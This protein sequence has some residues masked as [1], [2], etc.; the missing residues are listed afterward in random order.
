MTRNEFVTSWVINYTTS[1]K[2]AR[3]AAEKEMGNDMNDLV[4]HAVLMANLAY[5]ELQK[6]VIPQ[7]C[8]TR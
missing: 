8:L 4:K 1:V 3:K 6:N 7:P 5:T 2:S